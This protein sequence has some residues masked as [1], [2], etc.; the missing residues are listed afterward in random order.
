MFIRNIYKLNKLNFIFL[1][2]QSVKMFQLIN[3]ETNDSF[4]KIG[5]YLNVKPRLCVKNDKEKIK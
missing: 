4:D 1:D 2:H 3:V 5:H